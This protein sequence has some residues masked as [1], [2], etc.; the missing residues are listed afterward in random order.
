MKDSL[1]MMK[2]ESDNSSQP[3]TSSVFT[4]RRILILCVTTFVFFMTWCCAAMWAPFFPGEAAERGVSSTEVGFIF[5][6]YSLGAVVASLIYGPFVIPRTGP[7]YVLVAGLFL[8]GVI[9]LMCG[10]GDIIEDHVPFTIFFFIMRAVG[11]LGGAA[12][13]TSIVVILTQEFP[14]HLPIIM[15]FLEIAAGLGFTAGPVIGGMLHALGGFRLPMLAVGVTMLLFV[16]MIWI[17]LPR[18]DYSTKGNDSSRIQLFKQMVGIPGILIMCLCAFLCMA[19]LTFL[20]PTL[21]NHAEKFGM[22]SR[23]VAL[24][25]LSLAAPFIFTSPVAGF[26]L[27]K[28]SWG[29]TFIVIGLFGNAI[30]LLFCAPAPFLTSF[31]PERT[32]WVLVLSLVAV[33]FYNGLYLVPVLPEMFQFS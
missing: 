22:D 10:F 29:K 14:G 6:T 4:P 28:K 2:E 19:S 5:G 20:D 7:N 11:S 31:V 8:N 27:S 24:L 3:S 33:G 13:E 12:C 9:N 21:Q 15:G 1:N 23:D 25:F 17:L 32:V 18:K 26:I 30:S 16:P